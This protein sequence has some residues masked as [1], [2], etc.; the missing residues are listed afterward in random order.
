MNSSLLI[1]NLR[2]SGGEG[3]G[4]FPYVAVRIYS[5]ECLRVRSNALRDLEF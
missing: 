4:I 5:R 3:R 2:K 1:P